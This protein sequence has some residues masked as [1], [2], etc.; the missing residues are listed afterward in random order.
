MKYCPHCG[1]KLTEPKKK[2]KKKDNDG[3]LD[4]GQKLFGDKT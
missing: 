4:F 3:K 1:K 2:D